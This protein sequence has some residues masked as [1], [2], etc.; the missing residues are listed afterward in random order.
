MLCVG[1]KPDIEFDITKVPT[2]YRG[3]QL[4][5]FQRGQTLINVFVK[6]ACTSNQSAALDPAAVNDFV[7]K[8]LK[9]YLVLGF[10]IGK[11]FE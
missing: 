4:N 3:Y 6:G 1:V 5:C 2:E 7:V 9:L 8:F 10:F 11:K